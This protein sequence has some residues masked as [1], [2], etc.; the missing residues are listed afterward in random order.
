MLESREL[1]ENFRI[2]PK[3]CLDEVKLYQKSLVIFGLFQFNTMVFLFYS[4][5]ISLSAIPIKLMMPI[6][7]WN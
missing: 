1:N 6:S 4:T 2:S 7:R 5:N 3:T